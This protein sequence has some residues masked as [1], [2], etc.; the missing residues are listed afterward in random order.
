MKA[1]LKASFIFFTLLFLNMTINIHAAVY[2]ASTLHNAV[3]RSETVL[4]LFFERWERIEEMELYLDWYG[5]INWVDK[6]KVKAVNAGNGQKQDVPMRLVR[7]YGSFTLNY[8]LLGGYEGKDMQER[9]KKGTGKYQK[10]EEEEKGEQKT[11]NWEP[12]NLIVGFTATGFH[13]GLTRKGEVNRGA[14]GQETFTDYKYSQFFDD[15]FAGSLLYRPYFVIHAGVILS[16][17][18][19]PNDDGTMNY[20]NTSQSSK[21]KFIYSNLL[22]FLNMNATTR[23]GE[24]ESLAAGIKV[25]KLVSFFTDRKKHSA[26]PQLTLTYKRLKLF[27]D[28]EYDAVWVGSARRPDGTPKSAG[29]SDEQKERALLH[30]FSALIEKQFSNVIYLSFYSEF[31]KP[32]KTLIDKQSVSAANNYE[33]EKLRYSKLREIYG[34]LGYNFL[35]GYSSEG[36]LLVT[37]FGVSR[38]WDPAI[39]LH[40]ENGTGYYK[41]G[42]IFMVE[43][44]FFLWGIPIGNEIRISKNYAPELRRLVETVDKWTAEISINISF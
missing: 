36:Y 15:V 13:Y 41:Y 26:L 2:E 1:L 17:Q 29:L 39:A 23:K 44:R 11:A 3:A 12:K 8:P 6:F 28:E 7:T 4:D 43:S 27:N 18:I 31:Q 33:G 42:G 20:G 35:H 40:R 14:A 22:S 19:E 34:T 21:R 9:L 37:S 38:F 24:M 30:T 16:K 32:G 25:N 5:K 10:P